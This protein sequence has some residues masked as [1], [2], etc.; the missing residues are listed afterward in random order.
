MF[1]GRNTMQSSLKKS[2]YLGLAALSFASVAAVSTTAS[3]KSYAKAGAYTTLSAKAEDR[4]VEAT[5]TNALYTKPGTVKG[6]KIVASKK[7]MG[8]FA[9]SKKSA[10]YFRA[11]GQKVTNRGSVYYRVVTMDGKYRGYVYGGKTQGTFAAGVKAAKTTT[12]QAKPAKTTGYYLKDVSK[13][14]I[15]TAPKYTQYK[16]KKI[17]LYNAAKSDT[18][19]VDQAATK[20]REGSLYYHV[21]DD[22]DASISG[23]IYAGKGYNATATTQ[24]LGGLSLSQSQAVAN[25]N[26]SVKINYVDVATNKVAGTAT[27]INASNKDSKEN[28]AV[29]TDTNL[30]GKNLGDF[31]KLTANLPKNYALDT[32][33]TTPADAST[34]LYGGVLTVPVYATQTSKISFQVSSVTGTVSTDN[35]SADTTA[36]KVTQQPVAAGSTVA[37]KA[38]A[39]STDTLNAAL[40]GK[41]GEVVDPT[42]LDTLLSGDALNSLVGTQTYKDANGKAYHLVFTYNKSETEGLNKNVTFGNTVRAA[43]DVTY[44]AGDAA[45]GTATTNN[46]TSTDYVA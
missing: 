16:A 45:T 22:N 35:P 13:N 10:T 1:G 44:V 8:E 9:T 32:S 41:T 24:D 18:F 7:T 28:T 39:I 42:K 37:F 27:W 36:L 46:S 31:S 12:D 6:A 17:N 11:Y 38:A 43:Y 20:T 23:W 34:A 15:W 14:T 25:A 26:N 30:D 19:T 3:A 2:L 4:N 21:T 33:A 29:G 5:G 40:Q